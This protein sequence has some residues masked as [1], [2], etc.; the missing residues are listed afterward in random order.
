MH[1]YHDKEKLKAALHI[2]RDQQSME[3]LRLYRVEGK[4]SVWVR[5]QI[6]VSLLDEAQTD[7]FEQ[8]CIDHK[9]DFIDIPPKC[10]GGNCHG[11]RIGR[12]VGCA[13]REVPG[14]ADYMRIYQL[15]PY[16]RGKAKQLFP[17][18]TEIEANCCYYYCVKGLDQID[19]AGYLTQLGHLGPITKNSVTKSVQRAKE[20]G[21]NTTKIAKL[22][23]IRFGDTYITSEQERDKSKW[24]IR[25]KF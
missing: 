5:L 11:C 2:L 3:Y 21:L 10:K 22:P 15:D 20:K 6:A 7:V 12:R 18:L 8:Y 4:A 23:I 9:D 1:G 19:I 13:H 25:E 24:A 16:K 17:M 14:V